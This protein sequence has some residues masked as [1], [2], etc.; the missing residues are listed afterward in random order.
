MVMQLIGF[1]VMDLRQQEWTLD[2][3][4]SSSTPPRLPKREPPATSK[5]KS[6]SGLLDIEVTQ[7]WCRI[8]PVQHHY[9]WQSP[10]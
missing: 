8:N 1:V 9:P 2:L 4:L 3:S 7:S 6:V 10:E 5:T